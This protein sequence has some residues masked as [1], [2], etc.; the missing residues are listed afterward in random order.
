MA[1]YAMIFSVLVLT[2]GHIVDKAATTGK[3]FID[4]II[5][6]LQPVSLT[7]DSGHFSLMVSEGI[8]FFV[9]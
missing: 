7:V 6:S 1:S 8:N 5:L 3:T 4:F 9:Q 2:Q